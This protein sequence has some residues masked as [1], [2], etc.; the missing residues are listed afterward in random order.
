MIAACSVYLAT[1]MCSNLAVDSCFI[2]VTALRW[3]LQT[4][5]VSGPGGFEVKSVE[6]AVY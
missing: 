6:W 1:M 2:D 5:P 4:S 3:L